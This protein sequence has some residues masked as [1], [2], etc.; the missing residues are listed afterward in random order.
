MVWRGSR[1]YVLDE[2]LEALES[3]LNSASTIIGISFVS[4]IFATPL[5]I[6]EGVEL[7]T[8]LS[9][10]EKPMPIISRHGHFV[11]QASTTLCI[12][13]SQEPDFNAAFLPA[14]ATA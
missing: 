3:K 4:F 8:L 11:L 14:I 1:P 2:L 7:W 9:A 6:E 10:N 12:P 13:I 5:C